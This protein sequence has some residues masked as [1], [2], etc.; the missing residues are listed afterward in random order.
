M[1]DAA[2]VSTAA[3]AKNDASEKL[4]VDVEKKRLLVI[5]DL[6]GCLVA[7]PDREEER[8]ALA[9]H[10]LPPRAGKAGNKAVY[11]RP[12]TRE[13]LDRALAHTNVDVAVW[14]SAMLHNIRRIVAM[15]GGNDTPPLID[16]FKLVLGRDECTPVTD[17]ETPWATIKDLTTVYRAHPE[18]YAAERTVMVDD[19]L[20]KCRKN[21]G[22]ALVLPTWVIDDA[23]RP[24]LD[25]TALVRL[26]D[27]LDLLARADPSDVRK[28]MREHPF[29][30]PVEVPASG[31]PA[32]APPASK[33]KNPAAG[34]PLLQVKFVVNP[35]KDFAPPTGP[36]GT[37]MS[38]ADAAEGEG[39]LASWDELAAALPPTM[40]SDDV[41]A[42]A[43]AAAKADKAAKA[44]VKRNRARLLTL[45]PPSEH[46]PVSTI[47]MSAPNPKAFPLADATLTNTI[48]DLVQQASHYKQLKKGANE[49]TKTLNRGI[50]EFIVM[51]ADAEP[52]EILLH[53]PLLCEDKNVPYVFVPSKVALG[54]ACGV[55]R[56]V[57]SASITT[58]DASDLVP[59]INTIKQSIEKLLI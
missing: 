2:H 18:T 21:P 15:V 7:R 28:W 33:K 37:A 59:Q 14:S 23:A 20:F 4:K 27:Y 56:S 58:N 22:N 48:L 57:I 26:A 10:A 35:D 38:A 41:D 46:L 34:H 52:I 9:L 19:S 16:R 36:D 54:R 49:A 55:S 50:S 40:D 24:P 6:N 8:A 44:P 47:N 25:D 5:L 43:A 39:L 53:L 45:D 31:K 13:F 51:A 11:V 17:G 42:M 30:L 29:S 1:K 32:K 3:I 12:H